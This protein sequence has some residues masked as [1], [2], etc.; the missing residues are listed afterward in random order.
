[1]PVT[2]IG[3][4]RSLFFRGETD[5][6]RTFL[7]RVDTHAVVSPPTDRRI[8]E[9]GVSL[10][11]D[12]TCLPMK[13]H[14]GHVA[15]LVEA[16][17]DHVL[18]P[19]YGVLDDPEGEMCVK[20]WGAYDV[21]RNVFPDVPIL[22]WDVDR[23]F[24]TGERRALLDLGRRL[25]ASPL[26]AL[27][28]WR[29]AVNARDEAERSAVFSQA[30]AL[31][32]R[33]GAPRVLVCGHSYVLD[34]PM[35]G[36]Q[37]LSLLDEQGV[38][39]IRSDRV[40]DVKAL[41]SEARAF[42]PGLKWAHNREQIGAVAR[43]RDSVDGIVLLVSFP[44]GPDSLCAELVHRTVKERPVV[45]IVLDELT[46]EAGLRTRVESFSDIVKLRRPA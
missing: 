22:S 27:R 26:S 32:E 39:V 30:R 44:C 23:I 37:V 7:E 25:G 38:A 3:I 28:A 14:L 9:R 35:M 46:A 43:L 10:A 31:D 11:V 42:S 5:F 1:M 21:T 13:I 20:F 12:E 2:T 24:G 41:R 40:G 6:V 8:M 33:D 34:D 15:S 4:P 45:S 17:V 36:A 16:G 19:R 29:S 18:V